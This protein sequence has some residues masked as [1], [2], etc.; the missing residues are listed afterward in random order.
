MDVKE[1]ISEENDNRV[2]FAPKEFYD[3][4]DDCDVLPEERWE[5]QRGNLQEE[6]RLIL[7]NR[8]QVA[9]GA[10]SNVMLFSSL[11]RPIS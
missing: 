2:R 4:C 11:G 1:T 9:L 7:E 3:S 5:A 10:F 6:N 8:Q